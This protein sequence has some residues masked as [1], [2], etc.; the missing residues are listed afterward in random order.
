MAILSQGAASLLLPAGA[1]PA[2]YE[3]ET[4]APG[5]PCCS[6]Q[7]PFRVGLTR[8]LR[9][10]H[11]RPMRARLLIEAGAD[12]HVESVKAALRRP[13]F[14]QL[15]SLAGTLAVVDLSAFAA[16]ADAGRVR[17]AEMCAAADRVLVNRA[18]QA[19]GAALMQL[20]QLCCAID[21]APPISISGCDAIALD[22]PGDAA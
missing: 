19:P 21:P 9:R 12:G 1:E 2:M 22:W 14:A 18:E 4:V 8:L 17:V 13:P 3:L 16:L 15:L 7:L 20:T 5:C 11:A 6:G 10:L